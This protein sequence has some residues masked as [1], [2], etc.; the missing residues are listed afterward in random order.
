MGRC[1]KTEEGTHYK[2]QAGVHMQRGGW[3]IY[4]IKG[5]YDKP[6]LGGGIFSMWGEQIKRDDLGDWCG[7]QLSDKTFAGI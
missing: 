5:M 4:N 3:N 7:V 1:T 2:Y 6:F